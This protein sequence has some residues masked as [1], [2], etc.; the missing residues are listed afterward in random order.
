MVLHL[1][2]R[3]GEALGLDGFIAIGL[4]SVTY[5]IAQLL[6]AYAFVAV[7]AAGV[8]LRYAELRA[9]GE[10][11]PAEALENVQLRERTEVAKDPARTPG[12][13]RA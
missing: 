7:F 3:Y 12:W 4:M 2:T 9:T 6:H 13:P 5:G 1:R 8:A 11:R 10:R